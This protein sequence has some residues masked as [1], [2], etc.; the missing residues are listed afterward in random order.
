MIDDIVNQIVEDFPDDKVCEL[1]DDE[2]LNWVDSDWEEESESE[3]DW[4]SDYG[5]GE[6]EN[7]VIDSMISHWT[8][9]YN[10]CK[11]LDTDDFV[12]IYDRIREKYDCL[13]NS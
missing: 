12:K 1:F 9:K 5:R 3:Y 6:A 4:Y 11:K 10:E 13:Y 7:A 8:S 2:V